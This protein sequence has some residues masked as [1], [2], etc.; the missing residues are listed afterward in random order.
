MRVVDTLLAIPATVVMILVA[1]YLRP[2]LLTM[3]VMISLLSWPDGARI[4]RS[5]TLSLRERLHVS[6]ARTFG[7]GTS[8]ILFRHVVP[9][10]G[11][12]IIAVMIQDAM[13]A[14]FMEAGLAFLGVSDSTVVSWGVMM[15]QALRFTYLDV[16]RWWLV[17]TGLALSI[18]L[19]GLSLIGAGLETA[20][21]PRLQQEESS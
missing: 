7:A 15:H 6:A 14:V 5:Q 4:I 11:P 20:M 19:V 1:A 3:I 8:Y 12:I 16:W 2:S 18:T 13:K 10:L 9:E 17:P 21:D